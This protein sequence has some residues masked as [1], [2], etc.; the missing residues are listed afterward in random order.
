M[1]SKAGRWPGSQSEGI[2]ENP[3]LS[4]PEMGSRGGSGEGPPTAAPRDGHPSSELRVAHAFQGLG[5][6]SAPHGQWAGRF[7]LMSCSVKSAIHQV[8]AL[9]TP[10]PTG[11]Y[12]PQGLGASPVSCRQVGGRWS[13]AARPSEGPPHFSLF[14]APRLCTQ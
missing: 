10:P 5:C 1:Q 4:L 7:Y 9:Q 3:L 8:Q 12:S 13:P 6:C 2:S 14:C 11:N